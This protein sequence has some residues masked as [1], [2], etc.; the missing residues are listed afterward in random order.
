MRCCGGMHHSLYHQWYG[1]QRSTGIITL[2]VGDNYALTWGV[3]GPQ[4]MVWT[5][6]A[7]RHGWWKM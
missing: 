4:V 2:G 1:T 5:K 7:G 3:F 6:A